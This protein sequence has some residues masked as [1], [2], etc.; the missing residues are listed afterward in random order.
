[1]LSSIFILDIGRILNGN[2][3]AIFYAELI[4][5]AVII[6]ITLMGGLRLM[7]KRMAARVSRNELAA[8][9]SLAAAIGIPMQTPDRGLLPAIVMAAVVV[10]VQRLIAARSIKSSSFE[11]LT[12][13]NISILVENGCMR[14][15]EM[16]KTRIDRER[17]LSQLRSS[18][19]KQLGEVKR[20][21]LEAGGYFTLIR[22]SETSP[23]LSVIPDWDHEFKAEQQKAAEKTVCHYCGDEVPPRAKECPNC[24]K[25]EF[26]KAV[27]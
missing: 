12:Q 18:G 13:G 17:L 24:G 20:L 8:M 9:A 21:Y 1:M 16:K 11:R 25:H 2:T 27:Y 6:Y 14:H 7:G 15:Q 19:V 10:V 3:P 4:I 23:G 5:R 26:E 22:N